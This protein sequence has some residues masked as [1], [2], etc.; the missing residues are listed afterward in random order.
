MIFVGMM[1][2]QEEYNE[3]VTEDL[4]AQSTVDLRQAGIQSMLDCR[5][6]HCYWKPSICMLMEVLSSN[7]YIYL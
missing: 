6:L 1:T 3:T 5:V 2:V 4:E 7:V